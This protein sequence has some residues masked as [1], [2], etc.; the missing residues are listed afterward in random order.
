MKLYM[1]YIYHIYEILY[2]Y[3]NTRNTN[4][5]IKIWVKDLNRHFSKE[6]IQMSYRHFK[7]Y[8]SSLII[9]EMQIKPQ[10]DINPQLPEWLLPAINQQTALAV[11]AQWIE[12]ELQTKGLL[13]WFPVRA[14][15]CVVGQV[16][17]GGHVR[18]NHTLMFLSLSFSL[19]SPLS[20]NK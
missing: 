16:P 8:L 5:T 2:I 1:K 19:P 10:W 14:Y 13:I 9:R 4:N 20:K 18:G 15:T 7:K 6:D 11:V 3:I 17:S 12:H